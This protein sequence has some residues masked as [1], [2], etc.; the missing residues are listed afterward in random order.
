[1]LEVKNLTKMYGRGR[2]NKIPVVNDVSFS[3]DRGKTLGLAGKSGCGKSTVGRMITRLIPCDAGQIIFDG[4]D[5]TKFSQKDMRKIRKRMQIVFQ[6]PEGALDPSKKIWDSLM[7]PLLVH[8]YG[9]KEDR[10]KKI[11]E[12]AKIAAVPEKLFFRYPHQLSGGEAQRIILC[13]A[14]LLEPELLILDEAT[15]MLDVS[16]QSQI[17][18]L[19]DEVRKKMNLTCL[20]ISHDF[21]VIRWFCDDVAI[22][23]SGKI[24]EIGKTEE[25]LS[26]PLTETGRKLVDSFY[27]W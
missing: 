7:N 2:K 12:T 26:N 17:M 13:R 27:N 16:V 24:L 3:I 1:M 4:M 18:Q 15:S 20:F 25:V 11:Y 8:K 23:E 19:L 14:L 6:N 21:D 5:I 9:S 22:M 10:V